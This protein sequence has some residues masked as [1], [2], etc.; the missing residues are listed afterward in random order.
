[1]NVISTKN[2]IINLGF[3]ES[4]P[5]RARKVESIAQLLERMARYT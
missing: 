5:L 1:M 2:D 3:N 4:A